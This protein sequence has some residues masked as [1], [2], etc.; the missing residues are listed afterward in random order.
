MTKVL[1]YK[2]LVFRPIDLGLMVDEGYCPFSLMMF[3]VMTDGALVF[4]GA[5]VT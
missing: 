1:G 5:K 4:A 2:G 3:E